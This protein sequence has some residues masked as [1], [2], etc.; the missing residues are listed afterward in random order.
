MSRGEN[1]LSAPKLPKLHKEGVGAVEEA[2]QRTVIGPCFP[3]IMRP[4][5]GGNSLLPIVR[6]YIQ[7]SEAVV[8]GCRR[9]K[10]IAVSESSLSGISSFFVKSDA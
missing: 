6:T 5:P 4:R 3:T 2:S 8:T 1:P 9:A 7:W 10:F